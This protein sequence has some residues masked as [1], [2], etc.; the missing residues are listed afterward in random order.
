[1][2]TGILGG[3]DV[4]LIARG[5]VG[6]F[7]GVGIPALV[8][9]AVGVGFGGM[10]GIAAVAAVANVVVGSLVG[11]GSGLVLPGCVRRTGPEVAAGSLAGVKEGA[12]GAVTIGTGVGVLPLN[13]RGE[14]RCSVT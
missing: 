9:K 2:Q 13:G 11:F 12:P 10:M 3:G 5:A 6:G 14:T 8:G 4:L 1:L 7:L